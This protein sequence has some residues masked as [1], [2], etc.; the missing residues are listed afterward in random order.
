MSENKIKFF[1]CK[2]LEFWYQSYA[3]FLKW[4]TYSPQP[5][6]LLYS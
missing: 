6:N 4:N 2:V 1:F 3:N 5:F